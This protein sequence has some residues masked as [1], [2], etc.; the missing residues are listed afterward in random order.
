MGLT[1]GEGGMARPNL[2]VRA[3]VFR[4]PGIGGRNK[5]A[6]EDIFGRLMESVL[7]EGFEISASGS[8]TLLFEIAGMANKETTGGVHVELQQQNLDLRKTLLSGPSLVPHR[9]RCSLWK[10][11][12]L[13]SALQSTAATDRA[14]RLRCLYL[15]VVRPRMSYDNGALS[16]RLLFV[17]LAVVSETWINERAPLSLLSGSVSDS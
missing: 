2:G 16:L 9:C 7:V 8:L 10:V 6:G 14:A 11:S 3:P 1:F 12:A 5:G 13:A 17:C 4:L 15:A